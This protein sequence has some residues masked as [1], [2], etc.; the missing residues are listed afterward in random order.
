MNAA[1]KTGWRRSLRPRIIRNCTCLRSFVATSETGQRLMTWLS[2]PPRTRAR[3]NPCTSS[4]FFTYPHT[5]IAGRKHDQFCPRQVQIGGFQRRQH[6]VVITALAVIG[7]GQREARAQQWGFDV[8]GEPAEP[9]IGWWL[10]GGLRV[11]RSS[12]YRCGAGRF[13]L[14]HG[15]HWHQFRQ[16]SLRWLITP[17][18]GFQE[19]F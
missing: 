7:A 10:R 15:N 3:C 13:C 4:P 1:Q 17:N 12:S 6:A 11:C 18:E 5:R 14:C 19:K 2:D 9:Q 8:G 16:V